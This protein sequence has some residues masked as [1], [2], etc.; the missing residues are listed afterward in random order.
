[1]RTSRQP[2]DP[3]KKIMIQ[4]NDPRQPV[5]TLSVTGQIVTD[6]E[7]APYA[8]RW[9]RQPPEEP[10]EEEI[11]FRPDDP[12]TFRITEVRSGAPW[13][14]AEVQPLDDGRTRLVVRYVPGRLDAGAGE[15]LSTFVRLETTSQSYPQ[16]QLP[17]FLRLLQEYAAIPPRLFLYTR[18]GEGVQR[19]VIIKNN[20]GRR[21]SITGVD[22]SQ[23]SVTAAIIKNG[24]VA[25]VVRVEAAAADATGF[26]TGE[27]L[28]R[29][30]PETVTVPLRLSIHEKGAD[31]SS[32]TSKPKTKGKK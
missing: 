16:L 3:V 6:L 29:I 10:V 24:E 7:F 15:T 5:V 28:I 18:A 13:L 11:F 22:S 14:S 27:I 20:K 31:L 21:F 2:G 12:A 4:T 25:N 32:A 8:V 19:D 23:D 1:Y 26:R 17:V 30:G 9:D